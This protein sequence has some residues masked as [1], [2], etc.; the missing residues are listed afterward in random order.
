LRQHR[1]SG[2]DHLVGISVRA[3]PALRKKLEDLVD[4]KLIEI[5]VSFAS[6]NPEE[7][8]WQFLQERVL[9]RHDVNDVLGH[10]TGRP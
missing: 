1:H 10:K 3:W 6:A 5:N 9:V 2:K 7:R 8:A 4:A